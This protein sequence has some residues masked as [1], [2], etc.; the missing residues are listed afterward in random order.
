[1]FG[2]SSP[3]RYAELPGVADLRAVSYSMSIFST[4]EMSSPKEYGNNDEWT[5]SER[6]HAVEV[7]QSCIQ[8]ICTSTK[9]RV[10]DNSSPSTEL[11]PNQLRG[12]S[13]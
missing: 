1:M 5:G 12:N 11:R 3:F 7:R 13:R 2:D 6:S 10:T 4:R 8:G 9:M